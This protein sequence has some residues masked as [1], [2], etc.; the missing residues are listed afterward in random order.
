MCVEQVFI[1]QSFYQF[2]NIIL[3][4]PMYV[5]YGLLFCTWLTYARSSRAIGSL[6]VCLCTGKRL[7]CH[8]DLPLFQRHHCQGQIQIGRRVC[9]CWRIQIVS[10]QPGVGPIVSLFFPSSSPPGVICELQA[11]SQFNC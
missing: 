11:F 3:Y 2:V 9:I 5:H 8:N 6:G 4:N 7:W 10:V 1:I